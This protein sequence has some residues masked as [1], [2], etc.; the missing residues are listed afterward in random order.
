MSYNHQVNKYATM[1][2]EGLKEEVRFHRAKLE[3][4]EGILGARK[5][6]TW[7]KRI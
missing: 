7:D 4:I 5:N 2:D 3:I 1:T 6:R